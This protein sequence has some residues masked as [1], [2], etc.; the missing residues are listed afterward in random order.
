[1]SRYAALRVGKNRF[2]LLLDKRAVRTL[3]ALS[4][5]TAVLTVLCIGTGETRIPPWEV[6]RSLFGYGSDLNELVIR[7]LRLPRILA[8]LMVGAA[9]AVSGAIFQSVIRNPLASPDYTGVT[10][11]ASVAAV[12]FLV[13]FTNPVDNALTLSIHWLPLAAF[14]GGAATSL[15]VYTLSWKGGVT[16]TRLVLI[17]IG[18]T[19]GLNALTTM[20]ML[21][22]PLVI[23]TQSK[24]WLAG[25]VYGVSWQHVRVLALWMVVL[26]PLALL[27][28]RNL[29]VQELGDEVAAGVGS[30]VQRDRLILL[31]ISAGLAAGAV[32]FAG[33][34]SFVGLI[35]PHIARKLVG[36]SFGGLLPVSALTGALLVLAA[37]WIGRTAFSPLDIPA[38]VFTASIGAPYLIYLLYR[39]RNG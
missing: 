20:L 2:S 22:G 3:A 33:A 9:L 19:Q 14:L 21:S 17:G 36:P 6:V 38:G 32:A 34:I 18:F 30:H 23:A 1:M 29:N 12:A 39:K 15:F 16:P 31:M 5:V 24:T 37:D 35:A 4:L 28:A 11:G 8:A 10:G 7:Q 25:T 27:M 13:L 26:L